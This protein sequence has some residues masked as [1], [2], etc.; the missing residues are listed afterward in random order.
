MT[1]T[2][3]LFDLMKERPDLKIIP[4]VNTDFADYD[5][6]NVLGDIGSSRVTKFTIFNDRFFDDIEELKEY[7]F[8]NY[9]GEYPEDWSDEQIEND[10]DL[11]AKGEKVKK[12]FFI[13]EIIWEEGILVRI[14]TED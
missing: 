4:V 6:G 13:K 8:N 2:Q 9:A 12:D 14:E 10:L 7:L 5:Y 1:N 11:Y 3:K